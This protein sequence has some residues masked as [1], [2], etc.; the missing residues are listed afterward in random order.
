M[1]T[2]DPALHEE[3][4]VV[5]AVAEDAQQK[6]IP[7]QF[8]AE[9][10]C[11]D[12]SYQ[13]PYFVIKI[14]IKAIHGLRC[15]TELFKT[16]LGLA[17][18]GTTQDFIGIGNNFPFCGQSRLFSCVGPCLESVSKLLISF[19]RHTCASPQVA[20]SH[21]GIH[22]VAFGWVASFVRLY[23]GTFYNATLSIEWVLC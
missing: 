7:R 3:Y 21:N 4:R 11:Q 8:H 16:D 12:T 13:H 15:S 18:I 1:Q 22:T 5:E 19:R 23:I 2:L 17:E 20:N 10:L 14:M 9:V 6:D